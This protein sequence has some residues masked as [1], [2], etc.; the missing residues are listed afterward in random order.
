MVQVVSWSPAGSPAEPPATTI[1]ILK[2]QQH[3]AWLGRS[4]GLYLVI[5]CLEGW[6]PL[7]PFGNIIL[8]DLLTELFYLNHIQHF[9]LWNHNAI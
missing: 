5:I 7:I 9:Y 3:L 4:R 1:V 2:Q 6:H 8:P